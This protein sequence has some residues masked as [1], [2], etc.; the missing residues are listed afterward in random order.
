MLEGSGDSNLI[1]LIEWEFSHGMAVSTEV[2]FLDGF[3]S[4][5]EILAHY[6]VWDLFFFCG[7]DALCVRLEMKS[8]LL[9]DCW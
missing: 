8:L 9:V 2:D 6:G 5:G 7:E 1:L 4:D 3:G